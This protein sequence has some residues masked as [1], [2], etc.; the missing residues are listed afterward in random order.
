M[1]GEDGIC[2]NVEMSWAWQPCRRG[3]EGLISDGGWAVD[4]REIGWT[5][6]EYLLK[7]FRA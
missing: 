4:G 5:V 1:G 3:L 7:T 6:W 2:T